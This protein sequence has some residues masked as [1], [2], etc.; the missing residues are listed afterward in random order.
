MA[1]TSSAPKKEKG[2]VAPYVVEFFKGV[3]PGWKRI[4]LSP[5]VKP[6]LNKAIKCLDK[7][8]DLHGVTAAHLAKN[9][10]KTYIRPASGNIF[11]FTG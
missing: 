2:I 11:E 5:S 4:L 9:G 7:Y 1:T 8:L 10:L 3:R 6:H